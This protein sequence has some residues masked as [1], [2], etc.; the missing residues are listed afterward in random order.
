V[1]GFGGAPLLGVNGLA[2]SATADRRQAV[3][4]GSLAS[5]RRRVAGAAGADAVARLTPCAGSLPS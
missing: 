3:R 2:S 4:N 1:S 5:R